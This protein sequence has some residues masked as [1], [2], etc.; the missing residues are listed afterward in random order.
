MHIHT[1]TNY[2]SAYDTCIDITVCTYMICINSMTYM[3]CRN[4][5]YLGFG[6]DRNTTMMIASTMTKTRQR[7]CRPTP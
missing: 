7:I 4:H 1:Y 5:T 2:I 6:A 3:Q